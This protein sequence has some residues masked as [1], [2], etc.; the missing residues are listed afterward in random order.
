MEVLAGVLLLLL[1]VDLLLTVG[2][3]RRLREHTQKLAELE[4][5]MSGRQTLSGPRTGSPVP[6]FPATPAAGGGVVSPE[7]LRSGIT[8][9]AF[10]SAGCGACEDDL[11]PWGEHLRATAGSGAAA[12]AV[13]EVPDDE[14]GSVLADRLSEVMSGMGGVVREGIRGPLQAAFDI[15]AFPSYVVV[16]DGVV[17]EVTH[18]AARLTAPVGARSA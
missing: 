10:Y 7:G 13:V 12:F 15:S 9:L 3:I 14:G 16:E 11:L 4:A 18:Q 2:V 17:T 5:G 8:Y 1:L 6:E